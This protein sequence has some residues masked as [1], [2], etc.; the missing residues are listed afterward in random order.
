M[1]MLCVAVELAGCG[2]Q[3]LRVEGMPTPVYPLNPH[4]M[5]IQGTVTIVAAI[6]TEGKVISATGAGADKALVKAAEDNVKQ[7]RFGPLP[8]RA[9]FPIYHTITFVY[10]LEGP[11]ANVTLEPPLIRV[12]LPDRVEVVARPF[13]DD[14]KV[15]PAP[16]H[17]GH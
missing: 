13:Q 16:R 1:L 17:E 4:V 14:S 12:D 11:P 2:Q 7:W 6:D 3:R 5:N 15:S 10:K 8:Q 9:E